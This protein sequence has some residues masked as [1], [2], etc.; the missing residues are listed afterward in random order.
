MRA[1]SASLRELWGRNEIA[2]ACGG[3]IN[4]LIQALVKDSECKWDIEF[5]S[6]TLEKGGEVEDAVLI[7]LKDFIEP[8]RPNYNKALEGQEEEENDDVKE[9]Y[10]KNQEN[11]S[12]DSD[13]ENTGSR[14]SNNGNKVEGDGQSTIIIEEEQ[15]KLSK[16]QKKLKRM[17]EA[18]FLLPIFPLENEPVWMPEK[19]SEE[20]NIWK[21]WTDPAKGTTMITEEEWSKDPNSNTTS[22]WD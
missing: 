11:D 6:A 12:D 20:D 16:K 15:P 17:E 13:D 21:D 5:D 2:Q 8:E 3:Y 7:I 14:L 4:K 1:R 9:P 22:G 10:V 19:G 18:P